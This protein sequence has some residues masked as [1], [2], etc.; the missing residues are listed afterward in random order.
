MILEKPIKPKKRGR[1]INIENNNNEE[2][3]KNNHESEE[4]E[5]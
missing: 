5:K 4:K 2:D 1:K 3:E